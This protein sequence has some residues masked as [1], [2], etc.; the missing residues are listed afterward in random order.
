MVNSMLQDNVEEGMIE[1]LMELEEDNEDADEQILLD[2]IMDEDIENK[3]CS[4]NCLRSLQACLTRMLFIESKAEFSNQVFNSF[5]D[6]TKLSDNELSTLGRLYNTLRPFIPIKGKSSTIAE[7]LP[8]VFLANAIFQISGYHHF[9]Q[10]PC[11]RISPSQIHALLLDCASL[12]QIFGSKQKDGLR[13]LT[14]TKPDNTPIT[15]LSTALGYKKEVI[16]S[17]FD[18]DAIGKVCSSA[19]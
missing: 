15:S 7:K 19:G 4:R 13:P 17:I 14:M 9:K 11:P 1:R 8:F 16:G 2:V 5:W 3:G 6:G 18:M 12:Y 10:K